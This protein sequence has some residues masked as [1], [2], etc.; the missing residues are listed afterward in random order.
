MD[1]NQKF[2]P[3]GYEEQS[4][5]VKVEERREEMRLKKLKSRLL[6]IMQQARQTSRP[7]TSA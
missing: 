5:Q 7:A 6:Q 2:E 3:A 4:A 1:S